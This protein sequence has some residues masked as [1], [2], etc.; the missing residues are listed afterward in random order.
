R[1]FPEARF[2]HMYRDGRECALS[3]SRHS[4][5]R[6]S[7]ISGELHRH[8][9][10]DPFNTDEAPRGELPEHLKCL[11]PDT[12]DAEAFWKYE[13]APEK[14]GA[15]W[16]GAETA[17]IG[18]LSTLPYGRVHQL[19]YENLV[20]SPEA[21][22]ANL[23]RFIGLPEPDEAYLKAAAALV[24]V[25]PPSWLQLPPDQRQRLHESCRFAM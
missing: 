25:K 20:N 4:A 13:V 1:H 18:Q 5:F 10:V 3:M 8:I 16:Q 19:R 22:L 21:E 9:G 23:I 14:L 17:A 11:M 24:R 12:F 2:V 7:V 6:L 15:G